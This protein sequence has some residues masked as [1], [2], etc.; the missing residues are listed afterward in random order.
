MGRSVF[1][2]GGFHTCGL[3]GS[4]KDAETVYVTPRYTKS[5]LGRLFKQAVG[6]QHVCVIDEVHLL[7]NAP[8][9]SK[10]HTHHTHSV[11]LSGWL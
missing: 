1:V 9:S 3:E 2:N 10:L 5:L 8:P 11:S 7:L 4:W 6:K